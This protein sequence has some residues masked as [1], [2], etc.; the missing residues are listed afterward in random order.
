[1]WNQQYTE[2]N[3]AHYATV[4]RLSCLKMDRCMIRL[5][6]ST[7][8]VCW[9]HG[10]HCSQ[11]FADVSFWWNLLGPTKGRRRVCHQYQVSHVSQGLKLHGAPQSWRSHTS[12]LDVPAFI[13]CLLCLCRF[14]VEVK[15]IKI[16]STEGLYRIN[17]KKAFKGLI[18]C[19]L[20]CS[21]SS[22]GGY[23]HW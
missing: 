20:F 2:R 8:Q 9:Q 5:Q 19:M 12:L 7:C 11:E 6:R 17:E 3:R 21:L 15:H 10:P 1:M 16:T 13:L 18:V 4:A 23:I 14:K 22:I